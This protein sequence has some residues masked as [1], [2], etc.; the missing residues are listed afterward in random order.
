MARLPLITDGT[1]AISRK[2]V[3]TRKT[4][5]IEPMKLAIDDGS[6]SR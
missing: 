5:W 1:I 6:P 2:T 3:E 4:R